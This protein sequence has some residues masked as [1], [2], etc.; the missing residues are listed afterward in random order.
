MPWYKRLQPFQFASYSG[1]AQILNFKT[2]PFLIFIIHK[3]SFL[4]Q[5]DGTKNVLLK[6]CKLDAWRT[7]QLFNLPNLPTSQFFQPK[8]FKPSQPS[9]FLI[10]PTFQLPKFFSAQNL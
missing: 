2:F 6:T 10:F 5:D 7:F 1:F 4:P 3:R 8:T 9:N